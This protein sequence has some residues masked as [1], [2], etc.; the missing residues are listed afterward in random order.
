MDQ[1]T[2]FQKMFEKV[3]TELNFSWFYAELKRH[4]I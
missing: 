2:I 4:H 3:R 1:V